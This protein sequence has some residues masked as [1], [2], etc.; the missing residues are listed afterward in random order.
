MAHLDAAAGGPGSYCSVR[1]DRYGCAMSIVY[2]GEAPADEGMLQGR[3]RGVGAVGGE[4][5]EG[6]S[7]VPTARSAW[8]ATVAS[9]RLCLST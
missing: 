9:S 8:T 6:E 4:E 5:G 3:R 7:P 1:L 2:L